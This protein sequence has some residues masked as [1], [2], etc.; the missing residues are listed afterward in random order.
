MEREMQFVDNHVNQS[1]SGGLSADSHICLIWKAAK[2][3]I[4][5]VHGLLFFKPNWRRA[6]EFLIAGMDNLCAA[7]PYP[8]PA[9]P[10]FGNLADQSVLNQQA[11]DTAGTNS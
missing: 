8:S 3:I 2:P 10:N 5:V 1:L 7:K 4:E 6:L 9:G 11:H